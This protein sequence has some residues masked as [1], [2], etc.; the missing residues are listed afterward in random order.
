[1]N[2][3]ERERKC[4]KRLECSKAQEK[5]VAPGRD[6][7]SQTMLNITKEERKRERKTVKCEYRTMKHFKL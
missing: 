1:M 7:S 2:V 4:E 6:H 5:I 3:I